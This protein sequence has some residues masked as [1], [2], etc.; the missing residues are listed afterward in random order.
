MDDGSYK[1]KDH[2]VLILNT[3]CFS[4]EDLEQLQKGLKASHNID[5]Q[6]RQHRDGIQLLITEP[7]ATKFARIIEPF[8]LPEMRYKLS[9]IGLTQLPK[10]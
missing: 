1:S 4:V 6:F 10:E 5:S 2:R 9:K 3:L 8:L 7:S